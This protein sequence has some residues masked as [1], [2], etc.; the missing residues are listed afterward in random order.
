MK[1]H[2]RPFSARSWLINQEVDYKSML[3]FVC[4][5]NS[6]EQS[7]TLYQRMHYKQPFADDELD[8]AEIKIVVDTKL[9]TN[10]KAILHT[11]SRTCKSIVCTVGKLSELILANEVRNVSSLDFRHTSCDQVPY[12]SAISHNLIIRHTSGD[13]VPYPSAISHT[14]I[15]RHT[16][17]DGSH[18][19]PRR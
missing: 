4:H 13:Q 9:F 1:M 14:L 16:S 5:L 8:I 2:K 6:A 17:G 10:E 15:I 7:P 12:P 19:I 18:H 11:G 3:R